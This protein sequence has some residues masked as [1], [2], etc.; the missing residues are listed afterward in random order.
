MSFPSVS[1]S[2]LNINFFPCVSF[3]LVADSAVFI[4]KSA[5]KLAC[6]WCSD[7]VFL[8]SNIYNITPHEFFNFNFILLDFPSSPEN[9]KSFTVALFLHIQSAILLFFSP[10]SYLSM[11]HR[12]NG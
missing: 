12:S 9:P 11:T 3:L 8:Y 1:R 7:N 6:P 4:F 10:I 2:S 5:A